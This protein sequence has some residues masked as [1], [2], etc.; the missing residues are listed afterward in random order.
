MSAHCSCRGDTCPSWSATCRCTIDE[1][2]GSKATRRT[3]SRAFMT[4]RHMGA[5]FLSV[6]NQHL[7]RPLHQVDAVR[8]RWHLDSRL[9]GWFAKSAMNCMNCMAAT[10]FK[11][12]G[13]QEWCAL[14]QPKE[15]GLELAW[16]PETRLAATRAQGRTAQCCSEAGKKRQGL[17]VE[18]SSRSEPLRRGRRLKSSSVRCRSQA[19][20]M[21]LKL[22]RSMT[23]SLR[24][25]LAPSQ[26]L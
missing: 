8:A 1:T 25:T 20:T 11:F 2:H 16:V 22:T 23:G 10:L 21:G 17:T 24:T 9:R 14:T 5:R 18:R 13:I 3:L 19:G 7:H 6:T 26:T 12:L 4:S 15:G